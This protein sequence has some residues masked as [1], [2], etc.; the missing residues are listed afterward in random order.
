M[1]FYQELPLHI[2]P[3]IFDAG[4]FR[5]HWY[6]AMYILAFATTILLVLY[7]L[8]KE[9]W[10]FSKE[11]VYDATIWAITG[12]LVGGRLGYVLFYNFSYYI[13][14]PLQILWPFADG[15]LVGIAGMSYHGGLIGAIVAGLWFAKKRKL[16]I[17]K[18]ID[19]FIPAIPL[20]YFFGRIGNFINGELYGRVTTH[21]LAM[22][23]G[24]GLLRH[25]SQLYEA[26]FEGLI[27]FALLWTI[28]SKTWAKGRLL[29]IY[30]LGYATARFL[31]EYTREPDAHLGFILGPL[32]MGQLL[33][34]GMFLIGIVFTQKKYHL[35]G[36]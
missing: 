19:L 10:E 3:Y 14:H 8:K 28:K 24:D 5:L 16:S 27:L 22:N 21:P 34:I 15:K 4:F 29:G 33:S 23:F 32:T 36:K 7:R 18:L 6:G 9:S 2:S 12:L 20:G 35:L 31:L 11:T 25:P 1:T 26:C 13:S 17:K 30:M